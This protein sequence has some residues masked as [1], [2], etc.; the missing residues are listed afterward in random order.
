MN[1]IKDQLNNLPSAFTLKQNYPN[2]FNPTTTI[3]YAIFRAGEYELAVYNLLGQKIRTLL[4]SQLTAGDYRAQWD[5]RNETGQ[6]VG[7]G[8]YFYRLSGQNL[9]LTRKMVLMR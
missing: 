8:I 2:P 1:G 5:G 7:S 3:D 6:K 4:S 9:T